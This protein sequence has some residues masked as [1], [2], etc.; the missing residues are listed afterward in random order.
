[1][2]YTVTLNPTLDRTLGIDQFQVGGTFKAAHS[3]LLPAGKGVNVARVAAALGS[4]VVTLGL[5]G[6][7]EAAMFDEMLSCAGIE[8]RLVTVPGATRASVTIL[9]RALHT[10]THLRE[11]GSTPPPDA[12][13]R[14]QSDLESVSRG[15]W[16]VFAGS[17]PPGLPAHTYETMIRLCN[18]HRARTLLDAS[19]AALLRGVAARPTA[20]KPNLF[21]LWQIDQQ[22]ADVAAE[23]DSSDVPLEDILAAGRRLQDRGV[24]QVIVSM[25]ERG[26]LGLDHQEQAWEV[27]VTLDRLA[28]DAVGSGDALV[29][30]WVSSQQKGFSFLE[31]LRMG[32]ACGAANTLV[33]GAGCLHREDVDRLLGRV[34]VRDLA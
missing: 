5:V 10:E 26:V 8:N 25:G 34:H 31:S 7:N 11:P 28:I 13:S 6:Q 33:A 20:L 17:L 22:Q 32:V 12:M 16:V 4:S 27:R 21:E 9:D 1:M 29:G 19:G 3:T 15:D 23:P 24:S 18:R 14:V 2:I 30:G